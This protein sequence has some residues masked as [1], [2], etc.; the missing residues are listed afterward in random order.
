[1]RQKVLHNPSSFFVR[2]I[3]LASLLV[4]ASK[5]LT[6]LWRDRRERSSVLKVSFS[7]I[8]ESSQGNPNENIIFLGQ[9]WKLW[10]FR[11]LFPRVG[12]WILKI[13]SNNFLFSLHVTLSLRSALPSHESKVKDSSA[14][15]NS[16]KSL[17][18]HNE[19]CNLCSKRCEESEIVAR[20][21]N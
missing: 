4:L 2:Y 18:F 12:R 10:S 16:N 15:W 5:Y 3:S 19:A 17:A 6:I 9:R 7:L 1:M 11:L 21:L 14:H 13:D 8:C 20:G